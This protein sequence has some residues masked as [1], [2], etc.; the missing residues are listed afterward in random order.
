MELLI[1][2]TNLLQ[3]YRKEAGNILETWFRPEV[4]VPKL[5]ALYA[6][7][8]PALAE[9][10]FP[11]KRVVVPSDMGY[12][13]I[14]A[15]MEAFIRQRYALARA[16]LDAPGTRPPPAPE[17]PGPGP[18]RHERG[19]GPEPGPASADAPSGLRVL[20]VT[21]SSVELRW[22]DHAEN[23]AAYI[24]QR[25][26]VKRTT[27]HVL[28]M[29][30][31]LLESRV[32]KAVVTSD[33]LQHGGV[34]VPV[35]DAVATC[36]ATRKNWRLALVNRHPAATANCV[37]QWDGANVAGTCRATVLDGDA[38]DAF[39][40]IDRPDRVAPRKMEL[41]FTNGAVALPPHSLTIL[42][43][44]HTPGP[45]LA[46]ANGGLISQTDMNLEELTLGDAVED[47]L[48]LL[49]A[50]IQAKQARV[51]IEGALP[52]VIGHPATVAL[53]DPAG[54]AR[55][56]HARLRRDREAVRPLR[57]APRG[58]QH[59]QKRDRRP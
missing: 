26:I 30:A 55:G 22:T 21:S 18:G 2:R 13:D 49:E 25:S 50:D 42:E 36:D 4:L 11:P 52:S 43:L 1:S 46:L 48:A 56:E 20:K 3:Q 16:Q 37:V 8:K 7:I 51:A 27:F 57:I 54:N 38:P 9:D 24:V 39:N 14:L 15:S 23:A 35:V 6:Q 53:I 33:P 12:P 10:P 44:V 5:Q 45:E 58:R 32:A 28:S 41:I 34:A 59:G 47:A 31:N 19:Q 29:Y 40:D 17:S